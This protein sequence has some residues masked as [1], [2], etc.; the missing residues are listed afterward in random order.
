MPSDCLLLNV[1]AIG[2]APNIIANE[3]INIGLN[4][5][6]AAAIAAST[7]VS[8]FDFKSLANSTIRIP[9]LVIRPIKV[10]IPIWLNTFRPVSYKHLDVY[11]RQI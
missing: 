9:F 4:L 3:V 1:N 6:S 5:C 2:N 8:P 7:T 11:K 10:I